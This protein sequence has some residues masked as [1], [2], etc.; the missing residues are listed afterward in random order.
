MQDKKYERFKTSQAM[1]RKLWA[2]IEEERDA[3]L[4]RREKFQ[5]AMK[6]AKKS[7]V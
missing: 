4:A 7:S 2:E 6:D 3:S 1:G 5:N